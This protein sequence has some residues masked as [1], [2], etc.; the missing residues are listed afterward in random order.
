MICTSTNPASSSARR[1][2]PTRPSIISLGAITSGC[3]TLR[4][5][6]A[7]TDANGGTLNLTTGALSLTAGGA[8]GASC[9][10]LETQALTIGATGG[11]NTNGRGKTIGKAI[12]IVESN[13]RHEPDSHFEQEDRGTRGPGY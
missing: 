4:A 10:P 1:T 5:E 2:A 13:Q 12:Q 6:G 9:D 11:Y 7:L 8:I 3:L